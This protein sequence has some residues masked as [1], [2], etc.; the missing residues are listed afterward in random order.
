MRFSLSRRASKV[1]SRMAVD[2][3]GDLDAV[4]LELVD[5]LGCVWE[6]VVDEAA[7]GGVRASRQAAVRSEGSS[8]EKM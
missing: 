4:L 2:E 5:G 7:D 1:R 8:S 3:D 6:R